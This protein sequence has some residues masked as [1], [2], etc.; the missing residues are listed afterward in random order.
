MHRLLTCGAVMGTAFS[1]MSA[2]ARADWPNF[3]GPDFSGKSGETGLKVDWDA[4]PPVVWEKEV[5]SPRPPIEG[6]GERP[7]LQIVKP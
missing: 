5:G 7:L 4:R 6:L 1:A 2:N 3:R